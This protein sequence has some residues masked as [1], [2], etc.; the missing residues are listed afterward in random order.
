MYTVGSAPCNP[1]R[2]RDRTARSTNKGFDRA[3]SVARANAHEMPQDAGPRDGNEEAVLHASKHNT[4]YSWT[5][6][7]NNTAR[8]RQRKQVRIRARA[9]RRDH[10][11]CGRHEVILFRAD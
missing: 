7:Q 1:A 4:G 6:N 2:L 11:H 9:H 8:P 3:N 10:G 5:N